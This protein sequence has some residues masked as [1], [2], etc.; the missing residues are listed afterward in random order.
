MHYYA[1]HVGISL[2]NI[3]INVTSI[4]ILVG[5]SSAVETLGSQH[6]GAGEGMR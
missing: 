6:N 1:A 4:S 3:F 5:M 2:A